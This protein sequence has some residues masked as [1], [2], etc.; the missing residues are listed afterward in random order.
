METLTELL[1][2]LAPLIMGGGLSWIFLYRIK[3]RQLA[4]QVSVKEYQ[5]VDKIIESFLQRNAELVRDISDLRN[6]IMHKRQT[7]NE[8]ENAVADEDFEKI[9]PILKAYREER[10][11]PIA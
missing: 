6:D 5:D 3:R 11:R 7:L 2:V 4:S 1:K 10:D 9:E 8:I